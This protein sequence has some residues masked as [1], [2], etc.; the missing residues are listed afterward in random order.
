MAGTPT[1][2]STFKTDVLDEKSK[3]VLV[4]FWATW[5]G[6]CRIQGPIVEDIARV[7]GNKAKVLSMD[8][9]ANPVV[10]QQFG[11][12]SIPTLM[13]FKNGQVVW[14][15]IGVQQKQTLTDKIDQA[16]TA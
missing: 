16:L 12:L 2:D 10:S 7:Y 9:D 5:C 3:P 4:D 14:Q 8:V 11:I 15:G 13:I 1:T 6:P